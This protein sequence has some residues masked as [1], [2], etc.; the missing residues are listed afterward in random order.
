MIFIMAAGGGAGRGTVE[1]LL[2]QGVPAQQI[3]GGARVPAKLDW[4]VDAGAH[5]R[6]ADYNDPS[7]M[8]EAFRGVETLVLIP[9]MS[10]PQPRCVEHRNALLAAKSAG[11]R[12]VVFLS[13]Q[14]GGAESR[15]MMTPFFVFAEDATRNSGMEWTITRMS[16]YSDPLADWLPEL[17]KMG[18]LPYP[19]RNGR[20][21]YV[22]KADVSRGLAATARRNDLDGEILEFTGPESLSMPE[23]AAEISK[24]AGVSIPFASI[25]DEEY[26]DICRAEGCDE[27]MIKGMTSLY[28]AVEAQEFARAS[29]DVEQLTGTRPESV[30]QAILR[31][32]HQG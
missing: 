19:V 3:A 27:G 16:L 10:A 13:I 14:S 23:V 22:A 25:T 9:T 32:R 5:A 18:R 4:M 29:G 30:S 8:V 26:G 20:V 11:V 7:S 12:R 28:H 21:A 24:A 17:V 1:S 15:F 2:G 6:R 31:L